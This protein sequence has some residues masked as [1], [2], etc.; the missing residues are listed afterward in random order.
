MRCVWI[1]III[2]CFC[3]FGFAQDQDKESKA[4]FILL[5][6][7]QASNKSA[8][9]I[10]SVFIEV[11]S[12]HRTRKAKQ[13][14]GGV[15]SYELATKLWFQKPNRINIKTLYNYPNGQSQ[16]TEIMVF[17]QAVTNS[18]KIKLPDD[19]GF[20]PIFIQEK[21]DPKRNEE[22]LL[23]KTKYEAFGLGF[24][25]FFYS[26]EDLKFVYLGV[27][28]SGEQSAD[29]VGTT[30]DNNYKIKLFFDQKTSQLLLIDAE[31]VDA[32]SGERLEQKY[33][34][35][36]YKQ[37]NG[38]S[39]AHKVVIHENGEIVEERVIKKIELNPKLEA[40]FFE[41]KK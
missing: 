11:S 32:K 7:K 39:F 41:V 20:I 23:Q 25:I 30:I 22:I 24:P 9:Q 38:I 26:S 40:D 21:G 13:A 28:K 10:E 33:F 35:S 18:S 17:E 19:P 27:A 2:N 5:K 12:R 34:F 15:P 29:V 1:G 8:D 37:E 3:V 31:F 4:D 6:A 14:E 16:L 36:E